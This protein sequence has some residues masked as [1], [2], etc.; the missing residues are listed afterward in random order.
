MAEEAEELTFFKVITPFLQE[1]FSICR[2]RPTHFF[3]TSF[4]S[5]RKITSLV[6]AFWIFLKKPEIPNI[7]PIHWHRQVHE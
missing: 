7:L 3:T 2:S 4:I 6:K 1:I 5:V